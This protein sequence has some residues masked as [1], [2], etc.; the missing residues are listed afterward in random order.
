MQASAIDLGT[1]VIARAIEGLR[2]DFP[3]QGETFRDQ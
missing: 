1:A 2:S 3:L